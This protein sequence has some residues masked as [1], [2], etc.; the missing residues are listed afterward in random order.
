MALEQSILKG[1]KKKLGLDESYT[2][3]DT[4]VIDYI[5]SAFARLTQ[6][7]LGPSD[8]YM[9]EGDAE[10]WDDF[11]TVNLG[12]ATLNA[13]KTYIN[14]KVRAVF[15]PPGTPHHLAALK[16]QISEQEYTLLTEM[17]LRKWSVPSSSPMATPFDEE[18]ILDGGVG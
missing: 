14:L 7:G 10:T 9:I 1:T 17:N 16:E 4:D 8:G 11:D 5:N 13:V 3:F 15:D 18:L 6:L 2:A 12:I